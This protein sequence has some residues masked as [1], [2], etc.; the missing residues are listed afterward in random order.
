[1][2]QSEQ[3]WEEKAKILQ[4]HFKDRFNSFIVTGHPNNVP[5]EYSGKGS[6]V[7]HAVRTGCAEMLNMGYDRSKIMLTIMDSDAAI[8]E[9]YIIE[10]IYL[11]IL[12]FRCKT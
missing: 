3:G 10:V 6:N 7:N 2:E 11:Y 12:L 1:M 9:L 8:P 5:G 4:E